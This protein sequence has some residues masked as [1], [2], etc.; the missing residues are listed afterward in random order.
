MI[1]I[2]R[3][4][5]IIEEIYPLLEMGGHTSWLRPLRNWH[6]DLDQYYKEVIPEIKRC[7]CGHSS[8]T[9]LY[10][11]KDGKILD[12]ESDRLCSLTTELSTLCF[13]ALPEIYSNKKPP[14]ITSGS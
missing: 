3:M 11:Y 9:D 10:V 12:K 1:D 5:Q 4:K 7:C 8:L 6:S 14:E 2:A 13:E